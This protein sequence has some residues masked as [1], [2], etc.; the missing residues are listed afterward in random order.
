LLTISGIPN[1][2]FN[3]APGYTQIV[4]CNVDWSKVTATTSATIAVSSNDPDEPS[5]TVSVTARPNVTPKN[6]TVLTSS[7]PVTGGTT[8]GG[9]TFNENSEVTVVATPN[10]GWS[11]VNW[12]EN[13]NQ[14]SVDSLYKFTLTKDI[15]LVAN[16]KKNGC[17]PDWIP[18]VYTNSTTAYGKVMIEGVP[19]EIGDV[20]GAF[21]ANECRAVGDVVVN[22]GD[23]FVTLLIQGE[24]VETVNF[25]IFDS[26]EC[27]ELSVNY[28]TQ[29]SPGGTIGNP[30]NYLPIYYTGSVKQTFTLNSGWNLKSLYVTPDTTTPKSIFRP[31][32]SV[33]NQVKGTKGS[34]DPTVPDFLNTLTNIEPESGYWVKV[35]EDTTLNVDGTLVDCSNLSIPLK[36]GWNLVGYPCQKENDIKIALNSIISE[37]VEVKDLA[38]SFNPSVPDFLNTLNKLVPGS[39]YWMKVKN[40]VTLTYPTPSGLAKSN[41]NVVETIKYDKWKPEIYTNSMV[42]YTQIEI[43]GAQVTSGL[44]GAFIDGECRGIGTIVNN[45]G[46][47]YATIVVNGDKIGKLT[48]MVYDV[49]M[50]EEIVVDNQIEFTPGKTGSDII[51][52]KGNTIEYLESLIPTTTKLYYA[53]PNPFNP[54]TEIKFDLHK[55]SKVNLSV[56]NLKGE[57]V[58]TI[59]SDYFAP[60]SY[61]YRWNGNNSH[62]SKVSSGVYIIQ[63]RTN[64]KSQSNKIILLK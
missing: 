10:D 14:V 46:S 8:S 13:N 1:I 62:N 47:S 44:L 27:Q 5:V 32:V 64:E 49:T 43:N 29:T 53:Y 59:T 23:A 61:N 15:N 39:G 54:S 33:L 9:G 16:F 22:N 28:S 4:V 26:S 18:V 38:K 11:F 21:V 48:F 7:N 63:F 40:G 12:T 45:D 41:N 60:G 34:Y 42:V 20:V 6:Y 55:A 36:S 35:S 17:Q 57:L 51:L 2:P 31:I 30:P 58:R 24:T 3:I 25:K 19:A 50:E 52:L 56:Y 37:I